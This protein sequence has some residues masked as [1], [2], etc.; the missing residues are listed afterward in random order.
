MQIA[1]SSCTVPAATTRRSRIGLRRGADIRRRHILQPLQHIGLDLCKRTPADRLV[2]LL[3][4]NRDHRLLLLYIGDHLLLLLNLHQHLLHPGHHLIGFLQRGAASHGN[5][6]INLVGL[7]LTQLV[8][9][10]GGRENNRNEKEY[11]GPDDHGTG[12]ADRGF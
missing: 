5:I 6:Q 12:I 4:Q 10:D 8:H 3:Q 2:I 11:N 1:C 9:R 7:Q